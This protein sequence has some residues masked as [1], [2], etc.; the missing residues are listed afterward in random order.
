LERDAYVEVCAWEKKA[1]HKSISTTTTLDHAAA[2]VSIG[3]AQG[4]RTIGKAQ[5]AQ[6]SAAE[7]QGHNQSKR[8]ST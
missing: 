4:K 7:N 6:E 3:E 8:K 2:M 5:V 1:K